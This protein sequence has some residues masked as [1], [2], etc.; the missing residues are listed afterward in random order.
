MQREKND[1]K[2]WMRKTAAILPLCLLA[3]FAVASVLL[4]DTDISKTERRHLK[5]LPEFSVEAVADGSYMADLETYFKDQL[6]GRESFRR[7]KA[8]L[9]ISVLGKKDAGEYFQTDAGIY[10]LETELS[11]KN[12]IRGAENFAAIAETYFPQADVYVSVIPDKNYYIP[13]SE[14][15]PCPDY[16]RIEALIQENMPEAEYIS[17]Y[18]HLDAEKYYRTDPHWRQEC[19]GDV[20]DLLLERM[21]DAEAADF[22]QDYAR[23]EEMHTA[24]EEFLGGYAG[25]SAFRT[26]PE[27]LRYVTN[28]QIE[29]AVVYDYEKQENVELYAWEKLDGADP[30]DFYLWGA[31][32]LLTIETPSETGRNLVLFRDSFGSSIAPLLLKGYDKITLIDLR[33]VTMDYAATLLETGDYQDVLFLYSGSVLNHSNSMKF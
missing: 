1:L 14:G 7:A 32:A 22:L 13:K 21:L 12:V 25:A 26:A 9:E 2:N 19:I 5:K 20:A 33:Y 3:G 29:N 31:R 18:E 11:E 6:A 27:A 16:G 23:A 15:Y 28:S 4:P 10:R 8:E 17:L 30:Y 24:T